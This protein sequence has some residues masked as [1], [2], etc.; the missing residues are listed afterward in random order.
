MPRV[1]CRV[2][3]LAVLTFGAAGC[4]AS[5]TETKSGGLLVPENSSQ[6]PSSASTGQTAASSTTSTPSDLDE[7]LDEIDT[8]LD[9]LDSSLAENDETD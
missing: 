5:L 9:D 6:A 2:A 8:L 7:Q 4:A 1:L 3:L